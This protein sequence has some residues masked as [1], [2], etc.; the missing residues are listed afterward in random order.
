MSNRYRG[1]AATVVVATAAVVAIC[2]SGAGA[3][4]QAAT[5]QGYRFVGTFGKSQLSGPQG[6]VVAGNGNVYV[7]DS[8]QSRVVVYSAGGAV[9]D[10]WGSRGDGNGQFAY[11]RDVA[12][13][14]NGTVWVADDENG[15][16]EGFSA[17]GAYQSSL[18]IGDGYAA[19]GVGAV[20]HAPVA[21]GDGN[22]DAA[23]SNLCICVHVHHTADGVSPVYCRANS[24]LPVA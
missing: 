18:S 21:V 23:R 12:I 9:K 2:T 1:I 5:G 19:R 3:A 22:D 15:R 24:Q 20:K 13:A 7:A 4:Q 14:P 6:L 16:A 11:P 8:N 17:A 10:K